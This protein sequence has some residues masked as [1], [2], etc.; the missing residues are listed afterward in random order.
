MMGFLKFVCTKGSETKYKCHNSEEMYKFSLFGDFLEG[1]LCSN[2]QHYYQACQ[3][4]TEDDI[5]NNEL[6][7]GKYFCSRYYE[8]QFTGDVNVINAT[9]QAVAGSERHC[10]GIQNCL[11]TDI[12]EILCPDIAN[13]TT[14]T[15]PSG[16]KVPLLEICNDKCYDNDCEDEA[17]C[18]GYTCGMYCEG[19]IRDEYPIYVPPNKICDRQ[20]QCPQGEDENN[21]SVT[22]ETLHNC[23]RE[24][25]KSISIDN[26][27]ILTFSGPPDHGPEKINVPLHNY[28]RCYIEK[29]PRKGQ[30]ISDRFC[31][32]PM[33][34]DQTNC[35]DPK[36]IGLTCKYSGD[37]TSWSRH[38]IC[39]P[40]R[41]GGFRD[42]FCDNGVDKQCQQPSLSSGDCYVH[43]QFMCDG[44]RDCEDGRDEDDPICH[45][46]T[47]STCRRHTKLRSELPLPLSWLQDGVKDCIDGK[48]EEGEWPTC[49]T[50]QSLRFVSN[51]RTCQNVY[52]CPNKNEKHVLLEE[53]C[54]G[55]ETCGNEVRV[56]E[57][58]HSY[59]KLYTQ[60]YSI[61][62][63]WNKYLSFC[64]KGL[65]NTNQF[66]PCTTVHSF[67][68]PDHDYFG[69]DNRTTI[70]LPTDPK[71]C[72]HMFG[73]MYVYTSC[74]N[75]CINSSCPLRNIPRYEMCPS[76]YRDRVGTIAKT[77]D[78]EYLAFFT[79]TLENSYTNRYFVCDNNITCI[80]Y[81]KV[82]DLVDDCEDASDE[83]HCTNHFECRSTGRFIPKTKMCDQS[84]DCFDLSDECD[85]QCPHHRHFLQ[86]PYV[87]GC[88]WL[89]GSLA[90]VANFI[91]IS[92]STLSL[93]NCR[94]SV[95]LLNKLLIIVIS[96]G[97]FLIGCYL[98][99]ISTYFGIIHRDSYC[100]RQISWITST[101]CSV[102]GV[103]ST[104]GS[105][106]SLFA[107]CVLSVIR[108]VGIS[109]S[110]KVPGEV[111]LVK[112][113]KILCLLVL[114][115]LSALSIALIPIFSGLEDFFVN[116]VKYSDQL[117][118]FIG[119][120]NKRKVFAVLKQYYGRMK[121]TTLSWKL[122]NKMV[123]E[124]YSHDFDY[125]DH[126][127]DIPRV[128]FYGNDGACL[129]K[130]FVDDQDPQRIFV[131]SI[132]ALNFLCFILITVS[133]ILI[134]F[135]SY[136]SSKSLTQSGG[137]QQISQRN[138]KMNR[139]ITIIITTDFLCWVP[140]IVTCV[141]HSMKRL[142]ATRWYGLFSMFILPINSVINPLIYDETLS[143]IIITLIQ[144][145]RTN[146]KN[147]RAYQRFRHRL[148][149][150][151]RPVV[152]E[153]E[154]KQMGTTK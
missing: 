75:K 146:I 17:V 112:F 92:K 10:D 23:T 93:K 133:Y 26:D 149:F 88:S 83:K 102:I 66:F 79:K 41:F 123:R 95:A 18:N 3:N 30:V 126:T 113:L 119:T 80:E 35:T 47:E 57:E 103:I 63:S 44:E 53:L 139:K 67:I 20:P 105:Q 64:L 100:T 16:M 109:N 14:Q 96:F 50:G 54:D 78:R 130:Y 154:M 65:N 9:V 49:G 25:S 34:K 98:L 138:R 108:V 42:D 12:D 60:V 140:F 73:E 144:R 56:C 31:M 115:V 124:M 85:E 120:P 72:D 104:L 87:Y 77:H 39:Q 8:N 36:R 7:C 129:F 147:T 32:A 40:D 122:T 15:L 28:T 22:E 5:T 76:Q 141:L 6:F 114:M 55:I 94:T 142:D 101:E 107:M 143:N 111:I 4:A 58:G 2:D 137:N 145:L 38:M 82:C 81:S 48:D 125:P 150:S 43:K 52:L 27:S 131:W 97:D 70:T 45:K 134:G 13:M 68:F 99:T 106:I 91:I 69:V 153:M 29:Q 132:L 71:T 127:K 86:N 148:A 110:M 151:A 118:V 1:Q 33:F 84:Y 135:H 89:I 21:C 19:N 121:N 90:V 61:D 116:G 152:S 136:K 24:I 74:T 46:M 128:R 11:N 51:N 62:K 59:L 117:K 37:M